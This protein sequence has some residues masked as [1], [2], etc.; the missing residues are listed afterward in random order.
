MRCIHI[1]S[2][3]YL[4]LRPCISWPFARGNSYPPDHVPFYVLCEA[5]TFIFHIFPRGIWLPPS[6]RL[7]TFTLDILTLSSRSSYSLQGPNSLLEADSYPHLWG[8]T[9]FSE[10]PFP[11]RSWLPEFQ[12]F[13]LA[14]R[15]PPFALDVLTPLLKERFSSRVPLEVDPCLCLGGPDS[16]LRVSFIFKVLTSSLKYPFP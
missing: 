3:R 14:P 6:R 10:H 5:N 8:S 9:P 1:L 15:S 7:F 11:L 12:G 13:R 4:G 2:R 16:L